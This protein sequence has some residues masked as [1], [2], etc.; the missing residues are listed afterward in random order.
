MVGLSITGSGVIGA[1]GSHPLSLANHQSMMNKYTSSFAE[2][3]NNFATPPPAQPSIPPKQ[4]TRDEILEDF[5]SCREIPLSERR[6]RSA[7]LA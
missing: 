7:G 4:R 5:L 2:N 6:T 1:G 3:L